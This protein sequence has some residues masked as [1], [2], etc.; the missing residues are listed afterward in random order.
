MGLSLTSFEPGLS[1]FTLRQS[2]SFSAQLSLVKKN[3]LSFK[4]IFHKKNFLF[5]QETWFGMKKKM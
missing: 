3:Y 2:F 4:N 1:C 5:V